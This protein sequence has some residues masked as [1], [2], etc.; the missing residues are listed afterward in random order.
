[1]VDRLEV[2]ARRAGLKFQTNSNDSFRICGDMFWLDVH[3][4]NS[5]SVKDVKI[6]HQNEIL[7]RIF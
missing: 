4:L 7:V 2:L 5:G 1:M 3:L 6:S